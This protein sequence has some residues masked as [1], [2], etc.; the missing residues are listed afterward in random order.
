MICRPMLSRSARLTAIFSLIPLAA[1]AQAVSYPNFSV[2]T[3]LTTN[4]TTTIAQTGDGS[5]ARL[6][7]AVCCSAGSVFTTYPVP[8]QVSAG[9]FSTFF[10]FRLTQPG[11]LAPADGFAFVLRE[12]NTPGLGSTAN[13]VGYDGI[14]HSIGI[15]FDTYKND[16]ETNDNHVAIQTNGVILDEFTQTPFGVAPCTSPAGIVGCMS[17]GDL[18]SVW[19][20]YDGVD[21][22]VAVADS[23]TTRPPD[24]INAPVSLP[25]LLHYTKEAYVGFTAGTGGGFENHDIVNWVYYSTYNPTAVGASQTL[26]TQLISQVSTTQVSTRTPTGIVTRRGTK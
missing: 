20:D 11:G 8:F 25:A 6:T 18:W 9:T 3:G 16:G 2:L 10:Q 23:S 22:H 24:L 7:Q 14:G 12:K 26:P 19:I 15:K 1:F 4:G 21:L 13:A 5:V 17:N